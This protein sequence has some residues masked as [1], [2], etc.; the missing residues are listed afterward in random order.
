LFCPAG[1]LVRRGRVHDDC[2]TGSSLICGLRGARESHLEGF[3]YG[4]ALSVQRRLRLIE[5]W[6]DALVVPSRQLGATLRRAGLP[7]DRIHVIRYGV[8]SDGWTSRRR[9][10]ALYAGRLSREKGL[11]VLLQA[12][13]KAAVPLRIAGDGPMV[14]EVRATAAAGGLDYLGSLAPAELAEVRHRA[15][16]VVVP[17]IWPDISPFT[18]LEAFADGTPVIASDIGGLTEIVDTPEVGTTVPSGDP[19]A[20]AR[21]M[22]EWWDRRAAADL[23]RAAWERARERYDLERQTRQVLHLYRTVLESA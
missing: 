16:F 22:S 17:S 4:A 10:Y 21:A 19:G 8:P 13:R 14:Q 6:V 1:T 3:A 7:N 12:A 20:L 5:R 11:Q 15:A 9:E 18:A 23:G 2:V